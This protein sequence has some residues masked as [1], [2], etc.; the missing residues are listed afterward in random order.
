MA[1]HAQ[2]GLPCGAWLLE[3]GE[4]SKMEGVSIRTLVLE[5]VDAK[6]ASH[7]R[8]LHIEVLQRRPGTPEHTVRARL[9]EAHD[10]R[11]MSKRRLIARSPA[12]IISY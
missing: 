6:G 8:E 7:I 9:S 1:Q 5:L 12:K 4:V 2:P 10:L 11:V 3:S